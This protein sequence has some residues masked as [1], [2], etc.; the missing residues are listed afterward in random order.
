MPAPW[1]GS[2]PGALVGEMGIS[3]FMPAPWPGIEPGALVG[4]VGI[5]PCDHSHLINT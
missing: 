1:P 3:F 5:L 2:E 4:E